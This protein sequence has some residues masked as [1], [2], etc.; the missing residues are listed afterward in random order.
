MD[1][2]WDP[3]KSKFSAPAFTGYPEDEAPAPAP[4]LAVF[5]LN[6]PSFDLKFDSQKSSKKGAPYILF[7][8]A[9]P[10]NASH[11]IKESEGFIQLPAREF[12]K[13]FGADWSSN[14]AHE[15]QASEGK[16]N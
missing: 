10:S 11:G 6:D 4:S 9:V 3:T 2:S 15:A 12:E 8:V 7:P 13:A 16:K 14:V 1:T 5:D